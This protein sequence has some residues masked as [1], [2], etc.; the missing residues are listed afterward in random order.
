M[1]LLIKNERMSSGKKTKHIKSKFFFIK[2]IV[3]NGEI[4]VIDCLTKEMWAD[5]MT[6]PLQGMAFR[7][8]RA[9]LMNCPINYDEE[10]EHDTV[11]GIL[12][13]TTKKMGMQTAPKRMA[14]TSLQECVGDEQ[15]RPTA[16]DR[17][18]GGAR[19]ASQMPR[20]QVGVKQGVRG[21]E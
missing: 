21:Q 3:D 4:K 2:D 5:V 20:W 6:K 10:D 11:F 8:M 15:S 18:V 12:R 16:K 9:K 13:D 19:L 7:T 14:S 1:K 17:P